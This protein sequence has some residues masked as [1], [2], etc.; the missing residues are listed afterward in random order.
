MPALARVLSKAYVQPEPMLTPPNA[1]PEV[2]P[3]FPADAAVPLVPPSAVLVMTSGATW[4][5]AIAPAAA[6]N[7]P[8]NATESV[9]APAPV[10]TL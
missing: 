1:V 8:V 10:L 9:C 5:V 3:E 4:N 6:E 2:P 7:G